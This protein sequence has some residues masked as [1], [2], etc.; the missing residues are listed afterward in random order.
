M[1]VWR[2]VNRLERL[3]APAA[4]LQKM[5]KENGGEMNEKK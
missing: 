5:Q 2:G 3:Q 4:G 1:S